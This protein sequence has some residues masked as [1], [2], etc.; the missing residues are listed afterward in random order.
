M[1]MDD[2]QDLGGLDVLR[3]P[4][5]VG[6]HV[7]AFPRKSFLQGVL[8]CF[9]HTMA[10]QWK[11]QVLQNRI[12]CKLISAPAAAT[13]TSSVQSLLGGLKDC[14]YTWQWVPLILLTLF[15]SMTLVLLQVLLQQML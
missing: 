8:A 6:Q 5:G 4:S 14:A 1:L 13:S 15:L 3:V 11:H 9:W 2:R 12:Q 10:C 7:N